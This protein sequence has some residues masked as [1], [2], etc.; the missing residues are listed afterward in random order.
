M[1]M[2]GIFIR[3]L[4]AYRIACWLLAL[5]C[6]YTW[7]ISLLIHAYAADYVVDLLV[8]RAQC[9]VH[10][11]RRRVT[12]AV[13]WNTISMLIAARYLALLIAGLCV[14]EQIVRFDRVDDGMWW[15]LWSVCCDVLWSAVNV[16]VA[17]ATLVGR[18]VSLCN[19]FFGLL[20]Q[21]S[22]CMWC[23]LGLVVLRFS[24]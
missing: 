12:I 23:I 8:C 17:V 24:T 3:S 20:A 14:C 18:W 6:F 2:H 9:L 16:A 13:A 1:G 4:R 21:G 15:N 22:Y 11:E 5:C 10:L 19:V 7:H